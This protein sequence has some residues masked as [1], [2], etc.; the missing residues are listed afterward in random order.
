ME[1]GAKINFTEKSKEIKMS[2]Y[3]YEEICELVAAMEELTSDNIQDYK[4]TLYNYLGIACSYA[5][6]LSWDYIGSDRCHHC[7]IERA[8]GFCEDM[9]EYRA[10]VGN[11]SATVED[12]KQLVKKL[13]SLSLIHI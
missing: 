3:N 1:T 6:K 2:Y 4:D 5:Y 8:G 9:P 13:Q 10:V 12:W 11:D 7:V